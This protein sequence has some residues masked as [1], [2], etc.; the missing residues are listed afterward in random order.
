MELK[1]TL[2]IQNNLQNKLLENQ[3]LLTDNQIIQ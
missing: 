2:R 1:N 3:L